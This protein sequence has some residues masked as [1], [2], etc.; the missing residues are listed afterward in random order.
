MRL[1]LLATAALFLA[2]CG[3]PSDAPAPE[4][5]ESAATQGGYARIEFE[6]ETATPEERERCEAAGGEV[7]PA[8][9]MGFEHC[10]QS[11]ADAGASC[12]DTSECTGKCLVNGEVVE[13]GT[14]IT[15]QCAKNDD[16]F[17]CYQE[18]EDGTARPGICVD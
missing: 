3:N 9:R 13:A 11:F 8:G 14:A 12:S 17:G 6:G 5:A 1:F 2:A 18:V 10:I 16:P 4:G 15:G 7:R